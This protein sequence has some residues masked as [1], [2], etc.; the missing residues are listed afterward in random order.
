MNM[1]QQLYTAYGENLKG[2]PWAVYP[3]PQMKRNSYINLNGDWAFG[4]SPKEYDRKIRVPFCPES[5]LSGVNT[6]FAE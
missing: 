6:H 1:L 2:P 4:L 3:R 5:V